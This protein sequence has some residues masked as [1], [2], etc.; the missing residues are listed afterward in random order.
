[1]HY[2]RMASLIGVIAYVSFS[3]VTASDAT[4][5]CGD[6]LA[7]PS[8]PHSEAPDHRDNK[9]RRSQAAMPLI[10]FQ[11]DGPHC[12]QAPALPSPTAP[13]TTLPQVDK[14]VLAVHPVS[15]DA[16]QPCDDIGITLDA[17]PLRGHPARIDHP[18][19]V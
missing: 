9:I 10:P 16:N 2:R 12:R 8:R 18:P 11:C 13:V 4:A 19:R 14:P 17:R 6:W 7:H 15:W 5:S 3:A 1:M